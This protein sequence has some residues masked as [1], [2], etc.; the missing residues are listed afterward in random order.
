[1]VPIENSTDGAVTHTL[2]ELVDTPLKICAEIYL[3]I[4]QHL[5]VKNGAVKVRKIYSKAE[6][7][8]QCR[9]WLHHHMRG[10]ELIP[11]S[12]TARAAEI[13]SREAGAAALASSLAA[14]LYG[15]Q[16]RGRDVQDESDNTTRFLVIGKSCGQPTGHDKTSIYLSLK[17]RVGALHDALASF[18]KNKINMSKIESRPSKTKSWE[19]YFFVDLDGHADNAPVGQALRALARQCAH[20]T[21]LGSYPKAASPAA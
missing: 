16:I 10:V 20:M 19:Y 13:A 18:K 11:T 2:D 12:S 8:S 6:V 14:E 3:P 7:F 9:R 15:L 1:V 4:S 5:M 17:D 21:I